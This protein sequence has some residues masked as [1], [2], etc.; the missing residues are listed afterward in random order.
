MCVWR[1][2]GIVPLF[3][4]SPHPCSPNPIQVLGEIQMAAGNGAMLGGMQISHGEM[5]QPECLHSL[6]SAACG[7]TC[8]LCGPAHIHPLPL[9]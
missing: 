3:V 9:L 7:L 6:H 8:A 5:D 2:P 1:V 4:K